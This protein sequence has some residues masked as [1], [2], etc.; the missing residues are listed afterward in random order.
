M[1]GAPRNLSCPRCSGAMDPGFLV[2]EGYG[3][4]AVPKWVEG[5]A[6]KSIWTGLK[7]GG[8]EK[9]ETRT[10]RCKRCG[11]LESYA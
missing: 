4:R 6:Q 1:A 10:Y 7:L 5:E 8:R 3:T 11:Y 9:L 2:D